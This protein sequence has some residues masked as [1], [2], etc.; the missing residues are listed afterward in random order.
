MAGLL[1]KGI[2]FYTGT[3][4]QNASTGVW[5]F[6]DYTEVLNLQSIPSL[7][8]EAEKVD[9]TVLADAA[10][11]YINGIKDFGDLDF[12]FLYDNSAETSNY[13]VLKG[14]EGAGVKAVKVELPDTTKFEFAAD[15][16]VSLD[17]AEVNQAL[18]FTCRCGLQ[19]D[20]SYG[21]PS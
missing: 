13:R 21:N 3:A 5:T 7:G 10:R 16:S 20:I 15:L 6:S 12:K 11:H 18:T 14:F 4:S 9:V 1:S 19:S 17:E 2:K 8:G